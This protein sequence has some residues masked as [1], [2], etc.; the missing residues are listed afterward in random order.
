MTLEKNTQNTA[1]NFFTFAG[2]IRKL[3]NKHY[4]DIIRE[5]DL[6][7]GE[8]D[9]L[10]FLA[11]NLPHDLSRDI[12]EELSVSKSLVCKA[13]DSLTK[14]GYISSFHDPDDRRL[15]H[16][17]I[18]EAAAPIVEKLKEQRKALFR[19]LC[20]DLSQEEMDM[21]K[22]ILKKVMANIEAELTELDI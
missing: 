7:L 17:R 1:E 21:Q 8:I 5:Y 15:V 22:K 16:L 13:V 11:N 19:N 14:Q 18:E 6:S 4:A 2:K 12:A 9:V 20:K 3:H 10:L